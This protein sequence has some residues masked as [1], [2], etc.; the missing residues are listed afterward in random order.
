MHV[1][2]VPT[3]QKEER[4]EY[5]DQYSCW[6]P[7]VFLPMISIVE[8]AIFAYHAAELKKRGEEV[9][10]NSPPL[11]ENSPLHFDPQKREEAWR[12]VTYMFV[13]AGY[14]HILFNVF[15]QLVLGIPLEMVHRSWRILPIY[16]SGVVAGS[17]GKNG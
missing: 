10:W 1:A 4:I 13:H 16:V 12:Y 15:L 11:I 9:G 8:L 14:S 6:P 7:P 3:S 5:L 2:A 17:L